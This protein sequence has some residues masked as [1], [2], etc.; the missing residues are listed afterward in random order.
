M[1]IAITVGFE[2]QYSVDEVDPNLWKAYFRAHAEYCT[3][4][5]ICEDANEIDRMMQAGTSTILPG[6]SVCNTIQ[7]EVFRNLPSLQT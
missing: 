6:D 3:R 5:N 4:C 7:L 2:M 1:L